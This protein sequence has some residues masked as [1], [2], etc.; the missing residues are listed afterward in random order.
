MDSNVFLQSISELSPS[1]LYISE[2]KLRNVQAWLDND[3]SKMDPVPIKKL[4]GRLLIT[5]GHTRATA[6]WL[7]GIKEIPCVWDTDD[8][9]WAAYA[10]DINMCSE[11]GITSV[12]KLT[13]R[14]VSAEDYKRLWQDR[15]DAMYSEWYYAV[16]KQQEEIIFFTRNST[17]LSPCDIRPVD[18]GIDSG[19]YYQL[20]A[21]DLPVATG[22]IEKYSYE[23][24]EAADIKTAKEFRNQGYGH[25]MTAFLTNL[26]VKSGKTATCRTLPKNA[27]MNNIIEKCGYHKL[28]E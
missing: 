26:I 23:F 18:L 12:A 28:Y 17:E 22:C 11:E 1:Q 14:I 20:F 8:M 21:D 9:D 24:W 27:G 19:E 4:A 15:C 13:E 2:E 16:L 7:A 6:A 3:S 5:D 10:A 25:Q